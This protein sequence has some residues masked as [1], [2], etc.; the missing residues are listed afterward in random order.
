MGS[1]TLICFFTLV[2]LMLI[3]HFLN[4]DIKDKVW[5]WVALQIYI[6]EKFFRQT[7]RDKNNFT[8]IIY[9]STNFDFC[10]LFILHETQMT[11]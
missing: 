11:E 2:F 3:L 7:N 5:L 6:S 8:Q 10:T 4:F 9:N 1:S